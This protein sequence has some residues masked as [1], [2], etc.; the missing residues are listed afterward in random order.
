MAVACW[1]SGLSFSGGI[2]ELYNLLQRKTREEHLGLSVCKTQR[3]GGESPPYLILREHEDRLPEARQVRVGNSRESWYSRASQRPHA[4]PAGRCES[5]GG[6]GDHMLP[7][8]SVLERGGFI[9]LR[10]VRGRVERHHAREG[11][12]T[13]EPVLPKSSC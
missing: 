10:T 4:N 7:C 3:W 6:G 9:M 12:M 11:D 1:E 13:H 2:T 5:K 8:K